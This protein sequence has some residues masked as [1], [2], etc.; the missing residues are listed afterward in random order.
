MRVIRLQRYQDV[1][2]E[3]LAGQILRAEALRAEGR[4]YRAISRD[5]NLPLSTLHRR[6]G[7][8][9]APANGDAQT[10]AAAT[11][12]PPAS[13]T[14]AAAVALGTRSHAPA[15]R[16]RQPASVRYKARAAAAAKAILRLKRPQRPL[17]ASTVSVVEAVSARGN[18]VAVAPI[19]I[20]PLRV[21]ELAKTLRRR[22]KNTVLSETEERALV[23]FCLK[24]DAQGLGMTREMIADKV[25][26]LC[27]N[28]KTVF[29]DGI[30]GTPD[31]C[32]RREHQL[33]GLGKRTSVSVPPNAKRDLKPLRGHAQQHAD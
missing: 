5:V 2:F 7:A 23:E 1:A 30:P 3:H 4:T 12:R 17:R 32:S 6:L 29:T 16:S 11:T 21:K 28:R 33:R 19:V 22:S 15:A 27:T 8:R 31:L 9:A 25:R 20:D 13:A 14:K 10:A 26:Q 24:M 18:V